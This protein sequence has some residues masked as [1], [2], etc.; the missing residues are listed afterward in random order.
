VYLKA[1]YNHLSAN[2]IQS[3]PNLRERAIQFY[4]DAIRDYR[5][6]I[7]LCKA[8]NMVGGKRTDGYLTVNEV[9]MLSSLIGVYNWFKAQPA[10]AETEA[11]Y[12]SKIKD[13]IEQLSQIE[14][15]R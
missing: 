13:S 6:A 5:R 7:D 12:R 8:A 1:T 3:N 11:T 9:N 2:A 10:D 4:N 14:G 15:L